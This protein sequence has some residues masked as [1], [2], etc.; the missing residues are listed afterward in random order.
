[1]YCIPPFATAVKVSTMIPAV[2]TPTIIGGIAFFGDKSKKFAIN[3][4]TQAPVPGS[5]TATNRNKPR[6]QPICN[7]KQLFARGDT[8][9][10]NKQ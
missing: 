8:Y 10:Y 5:G 2:R 4:P 7:G 6:K 3:E 1:M 9:N